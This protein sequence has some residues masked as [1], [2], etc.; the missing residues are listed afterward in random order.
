MSDELIFTSGA[1]LR[2]AGLAYES[3]AFIPG[4]VASV[5]VW[6]ASGRISLAMQGHAAH[7]G[8]VFDAVQARAVA[9]ELL[10]AAAAAEGIESARRAG[11]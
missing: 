9:A 10:T 6:S 1:N 8:M 11:Q 2:P 4:W 7:S 5:R 3:S